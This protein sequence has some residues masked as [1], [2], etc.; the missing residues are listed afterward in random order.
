MKNL[1]N[2]FQLYSAKHGVINYLAK[3]GVLQCHV[4]ALAGWLGNCCSSHFVY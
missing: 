3:T 4:G 1:A 2:C